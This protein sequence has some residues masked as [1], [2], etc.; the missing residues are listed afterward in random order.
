MAAGPSAGYV[1]AAKGAGARRLAIWLCL[2]GLPLAYES[3]GLLPGASRFYGGDAS[4]WFSGLDLRLA[5]TLIGLLALVWGLHRS[6]RNLQSIGWPRH[7]SAWQIAIGAALVLGAV[8]LAFT[9]P[10]TVSGASSGLSATTPVTHLERLWQVGLAV[11]EA[12]LQE[13]I[14]RGALICWLE[15]SLGTGGAALFSGASYVMFHPGLAVTWQTLLISAFL[16]TVYTSLYLW[17]R[18]VLP[19]T[20]LHFLIVAGQLLAPVGS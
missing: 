17:R 1:A 4:Y 10:T 20:L 13:L 6:G 7:L 11:I 18:S 5:L 19:S 8:A 15:P 12:P 2:V 14:W 9:H 16:T 3:S